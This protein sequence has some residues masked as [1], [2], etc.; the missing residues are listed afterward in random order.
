MPHPTGHIVTTAAQ[1]PSFATSGTER[2]RDIQPK[3][4]PPSLLQSQPTKHQK[5][6]ES[7]FQGPAWS[8]RAFRDFGV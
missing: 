1:T 7:D 4:T 6:C 3:T 8:E 2:R 5:Q